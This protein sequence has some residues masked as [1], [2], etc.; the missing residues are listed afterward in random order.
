MPRSVADLELLG[1]GDGLT[2]NI[3]RNA[4]LR[5]FR[6]GLAVVVDVMAPPGATAVA[7]VPSSVQPAS[8]Q[9]ASVQPVPAQPV[10]A[11]MPAPAAPAPIAA[12]VPAPSAPV[13]AVA[14]AGCCRP[15]GD[16]FGPDGHHAG[17]A[18]H[19]R[20]ARAGHVRAVGVEHRGGGP[21][22]R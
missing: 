10:A 6:S 21:T 18:R 20:N 8:V 4:Q 1:S 9:P 14:G 19:H 7:A 2:F 22:G 11:A 16:G 17:G 5:H 12:A 15:A 3:P 13:P